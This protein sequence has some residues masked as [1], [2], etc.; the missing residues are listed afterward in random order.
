MSDR[1][2]PGFLVA[3][4]SLKCPFFGHTVVLLVEHGEAGSF[5][6]VVNRP[7]ELQFREILDELGLL[8]DGSEVSEIPVML[9]GPVAP[10]SG[11]IIFGPPESGTD[12]STIV[13]SDSLAVS[14]SIEMLGEVARG[15]GPTH[16]MMVLGYSG[17]GAGQLE[18]EM[19][20]G[21]WIPV[22]VTPEILFDTPVQDRWSRALASLGIDPARVATTG[23][24]S[25]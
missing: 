3:A 2:A 5:G 6:F 12:D 25:A 11:W 18:R 15:R 7:S 1:L 19:R 10:E 24:A 22:D 20:E 16:R 21:S 8:E 4:P 9:G 13:V 14:A 17:W 23:I